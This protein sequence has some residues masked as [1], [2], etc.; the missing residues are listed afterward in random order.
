MKIKITF[1]QTNI[2]I[3]EALYFPFCCFSSIYFILF[4]LTH[5]K[6]ASNLLVIA[7]HSLETVLEI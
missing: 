1:I 5:N 4:Y 7:K 3:N 6:T 2:F